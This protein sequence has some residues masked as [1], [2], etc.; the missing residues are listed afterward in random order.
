M[1]STQTYAPMVDIPNGWVSVG[2]DNT[3]LPYNAHNPSP[4][5]WGLTGE[6]NEEIT[7]YIMCC[8]EPENGIGDILEDEPAAEID[9]D[10]ERSAAEIAVMDYHHPIWYDRRHGYEGTTHQMAEEFCANVG[11]RRLCPLEAYCPDGIPDQTT[12]KALYLD[13][14]PFNGEQW[15]PVSTRGGGAPDWVAIG[16]VGGYPTST[17]GTYKDFENLATWKESGAPSIH[18]EHVLCCADEER[19]DQVETLEKIMKDLV[20]PVWFDQSDGWN[21]G[22]Y[23]EAVA[24]C[25][26]KGGSELCKYNAY[27]PYG[28]GKPVMGGHRH[29][30]DRS[31]E[32]WAPLGEI[33]NGWVQIGQKYQNSATTCMTFDWLEGSSPGTWGRVDQFTGTKKFIMCCTPEASQE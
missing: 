33:E 10:I 31:G 13:R 7:R 11:G 16:T 9:V 6:G 1:K 23:E 19:V 2:P 4:P 26:S 17:C 27:C 32:Q 12:H 20:K 29:D 28:P 22:S 15:A 18:K 3:C 24:F 14:T 30:F 8:R 5:E 25:S 21:G